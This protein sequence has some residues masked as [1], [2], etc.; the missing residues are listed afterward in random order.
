MSHREWIKMEWQKSTWEINTVFLLCFPGGICWKENGILNLGSAGNRFC[1]SLRDP[2][3]LPWDWELRHSHIPGW[4][5]RKG[6]SDW[7]FCDHFR[8]ESTQKPNFSLILL[9]WELGNGK[10]LEF[11][12]RGKAKGN[13][14]PKILKLSHKSPI[15]QLFLDLRVWQCQSLLWN[16]IPADFV[17]CKLSCCSGELKELSSE[18]TKKFLLEFFQE[19]SLEAGATPE[20]HNSRPE[21][22]LSPCS[23]PIPAFSGEITGQ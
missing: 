17:L 2:N 3:S 12:G 4:K 20:I 21:F 11:A 22:L 8:K 14:T 15:S 5:K 13:S 1:R 10:G 19:D 16:K 23:L 18:K 6:Q 7:I 9:K